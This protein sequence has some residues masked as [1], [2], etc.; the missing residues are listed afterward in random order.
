[1]VSLFT[2]ISTGPHATLFEKY[3]LNRTG[4]DH[5]CRAFQKIPS[6]RGQRGNRA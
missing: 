4:S 3:I 2:V 5:S 6:R 1:M